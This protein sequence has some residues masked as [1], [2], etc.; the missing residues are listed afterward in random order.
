MQAYQ[1]TVNYQISTLDY[2]SEIHISID[3]SGATEH[4]K[5]L[6]KNT[7]Q[8][9]VP[10][11][12]FWAAREA[13]LVVKQLC[14]KYSGSRLVLCISGGLDSQAMLYAFLA[15]GVTFDVAVMSFN[16]GLNDHDV[17]HALALLSQLGIS[18]QIHK[19]DIRAF[20]ESGDFMSYAIRGSTGSPQFAAHVWLA[21]QVQGVPVFAGEPWHAVT[22]P[23]RQHN[24]LYVPEYKEYATEIALAKQGRAAVSHFFESSAAWMLA[25]LN[26]P[27]YHLRYRDDSDPLGSYR[28][29]FLFYR[30]LG[31]PVS[32]PA[33]QVKLTGFERL[34]SLIATEKNI[35]N[36]YHFNDLYRRPL[37]KLFP[38]PAK[39]IFQIEGFNGDFWSEL[40]ASF[41]STR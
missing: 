40:S 32:L 31:F 3:E 17:G 4:R 24:Q 6:F 7:S 16:D 30:S 25:L 35:A 12:A 38:A 39:R 15:A 37:E 8:I 10:T 26:I 28:S 20:Y 22:S 9:Q 11:G 19:L 33:G 21:E 18:P 34:Y 27:E 23:N 29:K 41:P 2:N 1:N 5:L 13:E 36:Y 14:Q